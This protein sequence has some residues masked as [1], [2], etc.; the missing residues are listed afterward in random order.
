M[1]IYETLT[2]LIGVPTF[3]PPEIPACIVDLVVKV[4]E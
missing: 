1:G 4:P 2:V 3:L